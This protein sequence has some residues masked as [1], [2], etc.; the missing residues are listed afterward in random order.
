LEKHDIE[1]R[2]DGLKIIVKGDSKIFGGVD[3]S[4]K[5][6]L[7]LIESLDFKFAQDHVGFDYPQKA[8]IQVINSLGRSIKAQGFYPDELSNIEVVQHFLNWFIEQNI[9]ESDEYTSL[10]KDEEDEY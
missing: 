7:T 9:H 2:S 4:L 8:H 3:L 5:A 6:A 1:I 10:L